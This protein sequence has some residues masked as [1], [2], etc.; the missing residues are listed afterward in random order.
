M[1][2]ALPSMEN[3]I[4]L[5]ALDLHHNNFTDNMSIG[6]IN[7]NSSKNTMM[8]CDMSGNTFDC[9]ITWQSRQ[10]CGAR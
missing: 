7:T 4:L 3:L 6:D 1:T 9:P 10:M 8:S 2:G 5:S